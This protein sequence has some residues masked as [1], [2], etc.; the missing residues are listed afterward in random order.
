[1]IIVPVPM[2]NFKERE[3]GFNQSTEIARHIREYYKIDVN[4]KTLI[5]HKNT[6]QQADIKDKE[7]RRTNISH[8]FLVQDKEYI[9]NKKKASG[10]HQTSLGDKIII[11]IDDV[12]TSGATMRECA[13]A[14]RSAGA[15]EI[16]GVTVARG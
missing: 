10:V 5:K 13:L 8:A 6:Q 2:Y 11:L 1:M 12:Y 7:K 3:R 9:K 16:W 4:E 14:L 15:A